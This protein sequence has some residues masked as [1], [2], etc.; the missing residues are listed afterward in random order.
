MPPVYRV[1]GPRPVNGIE[2]GE[3]LEEPIS[4][5]EESDLLASGRI[6]IVPSTY[7]VV[8]PLEVY[9]AK[10][11]ETFT[12]AL[13]AGQERALIEAG[14]IE[15]EPEDGPDELER[16]KRA[17]LDKKAAELGV[18]APDDLPNKGAVIDAI[19][20]ANSAANSAESEE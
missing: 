14:H 2:P 12:E 18:E 5:A 20:A 3:R 13:T 11:D 15:Q 10:P 4:E 8:G 16:L 6:E 9:G 19:R 17:E 7:R 1:S